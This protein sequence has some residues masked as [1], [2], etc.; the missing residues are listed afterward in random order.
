MK[1]AEAAGFGFYFEHDNVVI[2]GN[3]T[4]AV[5]VRAK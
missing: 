5:A 3:G 2:V 1:E 4:Q